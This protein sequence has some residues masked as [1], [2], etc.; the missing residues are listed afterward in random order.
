[1]DSFEKKLWS[2]GFN[3]IAGVDEAGRGALAGPVVA[4]AVIFPYGTENFGLKDSKKLTAARRESLFK[5]IEQ[6]AVSIGIGV[7][8]PEE[9][10]RINIL[11]ATLKAME[12]ALS[13]LS[14][15]PDYVIIDGNQS[16]NSDIPHETIVKGDDRSFSI[17]AAS[18]IAKVARDRMMASLHDKFPDYN[19]SS[20]K[21]YGTEE[22]RGAIYKYGM[23]SVHRKSFILKTREGKQLSM[24]KR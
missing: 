10:D 17:A 12:A 15:R 11:R 21:G 7:V 18:I 2:A 3:L 19:F 6:K 24:F 5:E 8:G 4:A 23:S 1:M 20:H 16:V 9:I 13:F 22:H 14:H